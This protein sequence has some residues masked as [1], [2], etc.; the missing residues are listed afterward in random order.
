MVTIKAKQ[1]KSMDKFVEEHPELGIENTTDLSRRAI[2]FYIREKTKE[3][4]DVR[5][6]LEYWL[7]K[8]EREEKRA[9]QDATDP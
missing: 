3:D 7:K 5:E 8:K 9:E 6:A 4:V 2:G 1:L